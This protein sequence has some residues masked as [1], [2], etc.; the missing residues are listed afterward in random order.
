MRRAAT[1]RTEPMR[2]T[3]PRD[4]SRAG[5]PAP[6]PAQWAV[7]LLCV[8][9]LGTAAIRLRLLDVPLERDEGEYAYAG[10][11]L[12][13]GV[14][15]YQMVYNMKF[16][17]TYAAYAVI[18]GL[19]GQTTQ[20]VHLGLLLVNAGAIVLVF[21]LARRLSGPPAAVASAATYALMSV[22]VPVLGFAAHATHFVILAAL[23][24][25]LVLLAGLDGR[26]GALGWSGV[27][28]GVAILAKQP[29]VFFLAFGALYLLWCR[30]REGVLVSTR[31]ARE[32]GLL[33]GGA[34][35]PVALTFA[36]LGAAGV[37]DRFWFWTIRYAREYTTEL[38]L[39]QGVAEFRSQFFPIVGAAPLLW[40]IAGGSLIAFLLRRGR[41][42]ATP[43]FVSFLMFS[44]LAV[45][46][47]LYFREHY[48]VV[49]LPGV[50]LLVG[51]AVVRSTEIC[52]ARGSPPWLTAVPAAVVAVA[53]GSALWHQRELL[54]EMS[55]VQVSRMVYGRN[56]FPES[57][58]L[59]S[60][61]AAH[62]SPA[63]RITIVGSEPQIYFYSQRRSATGYIYTYG[64]VEN[65]PYAQRMQE[66][67]IREIEA[68]RPE[69]LAFVNI[70]TSWLRRPGSPNLLF[71]WIR[72]YWDGNYEVRGLVEVLPTGES[73]FTWDDAA[74]GA[75]PATDTYILVGRRK[76]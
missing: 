74:V 72:A 70:R 22:G 75:R 50:A 37:F 39:G 62:T 73:R 28:F 17:G 42:Q 2:K 56:P 55:P 14:P 20:A 12:L 9:L 15:P 60:H 4:K 59:A 69:F 67:M 41:P 52:R 58:E 10:Q 54:F 44:F 7:L 65:Q 27:L 46:P 16:P 25:V 36:A 45:C 61:S 29:G 63:D 47:G 64:L 19:F 71:E 3:R 43:F 49:F 57:P 51:H 53:L 21:L 68:A 32:L 34:A 11:L 33:L 48:F 6:A 40:L 1:I 30:W 5:G 8:V 38:T 26:R 66:E 13:Q 31:T 18:L 24:G 23:G 35:M 76:R